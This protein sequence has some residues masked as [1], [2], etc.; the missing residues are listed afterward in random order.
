MYDLQISMSEGEKITTKSDK[1]VT[2][3]LRY[4]SKLRDMFPLKLKKQEVKKE[5]YI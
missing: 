4:I 2:V 3:W 5:K 1:H